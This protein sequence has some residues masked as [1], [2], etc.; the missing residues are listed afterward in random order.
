[1]SSHRLRTRPVAVVIAVVVVAALLTAAAL[2]IAQINARFP[3]PTVVEYQLGDRLVVEGVELCFTDARIIGYDELKLLQPDYEIN[4]FD[5]QLK[6]FDPSRLRFIM[7]D[8]DVRR[9]SPGERPFSLTWLYA[10]S[11]T[12]RNGLEL[13]L[14]ESLN[15]ALP[16]SIV[17]NSETTH[18]VLL[19]ERVDDQYLSRAEWEA[20]EELP[21]DLVANVY[22]TELV[23]HILNNEN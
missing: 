20:A 17:E 8:V 11:G 4:T 7:V 23:I 14:F 19:Y 2:R 3:N 5:E 12:W 13:F 6:P 9:I 1:M 18:V 21:F 15:A 10:Q 22:P 16:S